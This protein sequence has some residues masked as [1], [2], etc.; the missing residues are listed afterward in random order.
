[1]NIWFFKI[2]FVSVDLSWSSGFE[3]P[4]NSFYPLGV[5]LKNRSKLKKKL[6]GSIINGT[7]G[8]KTWVWNELWPKLIHQHPAINKGL[9]K[10][11]C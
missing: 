6:T 11:L 2:I 4:M 10:E 5:A 3:N 8:G 7:K 1:M 9:L